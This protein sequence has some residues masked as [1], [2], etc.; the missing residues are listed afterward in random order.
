M[1]NGNRLRFV[2]RMRMLQ[3]ENNITL[4]A[5]SARCLHRLPYSQGEGPAKAGFNSP[6]SVVWLFISIARLRATRG[7]DPP[8]VPLSRDRQPDAT[9]VGKKVRFFSLA[10]GGALRRKAGAAGPPRGGLI[11]DVRLLGFSS[12]SP[13]REQNRNLRSVCAKNRLSAHKQNAL[14]V[15][16]APF[17]KKARP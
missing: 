9:K 5:S 12:S 7:N 10:S 16:G 14:K 13:D 11:A 4:S 2:S 17:F 15:F 1:A 3:R 8:R 6:R